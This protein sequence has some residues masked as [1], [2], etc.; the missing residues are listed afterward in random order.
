MDKFFS[1]KACERCKKELKIRKMSIMNEDTLC[2]DCIEEEKRHPRYK[3]AKEREAEEV[4][5]GNYKYKGL[6]AGKKY[7]FNTE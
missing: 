7:P 4:R 1:A 3:E 6:F 5:K 2:M